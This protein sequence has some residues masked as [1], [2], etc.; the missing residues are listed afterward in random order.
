M[1]RPSHDG[2]SLDCP[3]TVEYR[4]E[5]NARKIGYSPRVEATERCV[6]L[7]PQPGHRDAATGTDGIQHLVGS[8]SRERLDLTR[9]WCFRTAG[10]LAALL[11]WG[12]TV[13]DWLAGLDGRLVRGNYLYADGGTHVRVSAA[14]DALAARL[15]DVRPDTALAGRHRPS[16]RAAGVLPRR[17]VDP[18]ALGGENRALARPSPERTGSGSRSSSRTPPTT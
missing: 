7:V 18:N 4:T 9:S 12:V 13:S 5:F 3:D 14:A 16:R 11:R 17:P 8:R 2:A 10:P 6:F 15:T 1:P